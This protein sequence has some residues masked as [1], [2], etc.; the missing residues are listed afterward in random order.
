MSDDFDGDMVDLIIRIEDSGDGV[1]IG[2]ILLVDSGMY[3]V[4]EATVPRE[5]VF[6]MIVPITDVSK[7]NHDD[8]T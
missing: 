2:A 6:F 7:R 5:T 4:L 1:D 3:N 8:K